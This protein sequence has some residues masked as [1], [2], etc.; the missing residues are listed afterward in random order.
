MQRVRYW[1]EGMPREAAAPQ[2]SLWANLQAACARHPAKPAIVCDG[3]V[4]SYAQLQRQTEQV[5]GWLQ[6]VAGVARG[7]RVLLLAQNSPQ[8]IAA[9]YG[10]LRADAMVVPVNAMSTADDVAYLAEDSGA[11]VAIVSA[12]LV[13]RVLPVAQ[14]AGVAQVL[15]L[16]DVPGAALPADARCTGWVEALGAD[17]APAPHAAGPDDLCVLPYTSGT[18]GKPKGCRHTHRSMQASLAATV[19]WRSLRPDEVML[20]VA[21]MFHLLGMQN[22]MNLPLAVG[23]TTVMLRRWDRAAA[24]RLIAGQRVTFWAAPP[25]MVIDFFNQPGIEQVDVSS[26]RRLVGGG[27]AMP[28]AVS[29]MLKERLGITYNEAYGMSETASFLHCNPVGRE[30]RQCLGVPTQGVDSRVVDPDTLQE[31]PPGEVGELVT[32]APQVMQG[33]WRRQW[34]DDGQPHPADAEAFVQIDGKRFLRTGDLCATDE[35]GYFFMRDRLKR[36]IS[37]SGYKVWPA[38]VENLLY[39]HPAVQEACVISTPDDRAG[40]AVKAVVV[41]RPDA[42]A[43]DEQGLIAWA[44]QHMAV[45]KAPRRVQFVDALPK[46]STGKVMWRELQA[47]E[48]GAQPAG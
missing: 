5:A 20:G 42:P 6:R 21:P 15:V 25:T 14:A 34:L 35:E 26:L 32:C 30:K 38:E 23:G 29:R 16:A 1:P 8:F 2:R 46:S 24:A 37:V 4:L 41:R 11:R 10:V 22:G 17:H 13:D 48:R 31:L 28:E 47:R 40:E 36:M 19:V 3:A 45:Y 12:D 7:H 43:L 27:A 9:Y 44:R 33:Y 39:G 18:T